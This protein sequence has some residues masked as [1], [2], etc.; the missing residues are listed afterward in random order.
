MGDPPARQVPLFIRWEDYAQYLPQNLRE[1]TYVQIGA[2]CGKNTFG[3]AVGGDPIW[4]YATS[5]GPTRSV[6]HCYFDDLWDNF[7]RRDDR[8]LQFLRAL[9]RVDVDDAH[10]GLHVLHSLQ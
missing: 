2:N 7:S 10:R 3:C 4:S 9:C 6:M 5:C 1:V 8:P